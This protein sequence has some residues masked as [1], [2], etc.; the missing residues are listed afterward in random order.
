M[1]AVIVS[2]KIDGLFRSQS[3]DDLSW[4][5]IHANWVYDIGEPMVVQLMLC[6]VPFDQVVSMDEVVIW[7]LGRDMLA[8]AVVRGVRQGESYGDLE[9]KRQGRYTQ[10]TLREDKK[11]DVKFWFPTYELR[12]FLNEIY[13]KVSYEEAIERTLNEIVKAFI[14]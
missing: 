12:L 4:E 8:E 13:G 3:D 2:R 11:G 10:I 7:T 9:I 14:V 5:T 6:A 1:D